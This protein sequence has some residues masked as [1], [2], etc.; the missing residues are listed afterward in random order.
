MVNLA[1]YENRKNKSGF[2]VF[3]RIYKYMDEKSDDG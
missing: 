3:G 2:G 1:T